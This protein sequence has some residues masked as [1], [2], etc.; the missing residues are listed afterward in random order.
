MKLY[1]RFSSFMCRKKKQ[2]KEL[3]RLRQQ[4]NVAKDAQFPQVEWL[5]YHIPKTAGTSLKQAFEEAF[6]AESILY[7]YK[8]SFAK[9]MN[10]GLPVWCSA[11]VKLIHGHFL[12]HPAHKFIYPNAKRIVWLRPPV[13]RAWSMVSHWMRYDN[14]P[15]VCQELLKHEPQ[16]AENKELLF[17]RLINTVALKPYFAAYS[18]YL[19]G[20]QPEDFAFIGNSQ[21]FTDELARLSSVMGIELKEVRLNTGCYKS[22]V[23]QYLVDEFNE[24]YV[25]EVQLFTHFT[26]YVK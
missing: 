21:F 16:L 23:P 3:K 26:A 17:H 4:A 9:E 14:Y 24:R 1:Q 15:K 22:D 10:L 2:A 11:K 12:A 20:Y 6:T 8:D 5:S 7:C 13:E 19:D 18:R 25:A